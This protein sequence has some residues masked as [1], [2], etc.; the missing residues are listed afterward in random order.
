MPENNGLV[1]EYQEKPGG[2]FKAGNP[3]KPNGAVT[4]I[5]VKVRE[6]IVDFMEKNV[7]KIQDS[8]DELEPKEKLEFISSIL[9]YAVP[10]LSATQV[11]ANLQGGFE[12]TMNINGSNKIY[13]AVDAGLPNEDN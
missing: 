13:K 7:D 11:E 8:F 3:G 5:S 1:T 2:K 12:I 6:S 10:K 4:K 9:S